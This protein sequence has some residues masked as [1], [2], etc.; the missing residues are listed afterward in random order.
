[1]CACSPTTA[2]MSRWLSTTACS[3]LAISNLVMRG[4]KTMAGIA[5]PYDNAVMLAIA[6]KRRPRR[7]LRWLNTS[8]TSSRNGVRSSWPG[9]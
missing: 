1:M 6:S 2:L 4:S 8:A 5:T 7:W 9:A 3:S